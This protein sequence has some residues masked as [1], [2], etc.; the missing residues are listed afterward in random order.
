MSFYW[1]RNLELRNYI[2]AYKAL[3]LLSKREKREMKKV[4]MYVGTSVGEH[5]KKLL[6]IPKNLAVDSSKAENVISSILLENGIQGFT[7]ENGKGFWEGE[8]EK[9]LIV[10]VYTDIQVSTWYDI[11]K[12]IGNELYQDCVMLDLDGAV[13]FVDS[14]EVAR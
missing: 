7:L 1:L 9:S 14:T 13:C 2:N 4:C 3:I 6:S 8:P 10:T 11:A 5:Y 12:K